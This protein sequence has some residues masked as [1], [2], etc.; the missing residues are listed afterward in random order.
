ML[1]CISNEGKIMLESKYRVAMAPDGNG[2]LY[3]ALQESKALE[4]MEKHGVEF[5]PQVCDNR[6]DC[7]TSQDKALAQKL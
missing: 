1:P 4:H 5:V 7:P 3:R 6:S 2:G